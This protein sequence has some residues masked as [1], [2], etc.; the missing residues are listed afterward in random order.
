M[1]IKQIVGVGIASLGLVACTQTTPAPVV[2][3]TAPAPT[4]T[5]TVEP[6]VPT[7]NV[8]TEAMNHAWSQLSIEER[9]NV[10]ILW[11]YSEDE[12]WDAFNG[13]D[14]VIPRGEFDSF[15][16]SKCANV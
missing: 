5:A 2:T 3:V 13:P 10:C 8:Y 6:A 1:K 11:N 9:T 7:G 4:V 15:F 14:N 16:A 12:A